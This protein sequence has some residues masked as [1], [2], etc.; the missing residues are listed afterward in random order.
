MDLSKTQIRR[1]E[2]YK[3]RWTSFGAGTGILDISEKPTPDVLKRY[4]IFEGLDDKFLERISPD[5]SIARWKKNSV[6]FEEGSYIDM[7]FFVVSGEVEVS[8]QKSRAGAQQL[9]IFNRSRTMVVGPGGF[10]PAVPAGGNT[11]FQSQIARQERSASSIMFLSSIDFNL[12][13]DGA[14]RLGAGE[15]FGE[16]GALSGW[17][18]S[19]TA[20]TVTECELVQV[21][22]AAL[23]MMKKRSNVLKSRLDSL[24]R[25]RSLFSQL[26]T[27]P[28]FE[29]LKDDA[30]RSLVQKVDLVSC[31][32]DE[33]IA[34]EREACDALYLVRSGFVKLSQ[35]LGEG[36]IVV[37]YLPKG[38]IFGDVELLIEG[39]SGWVFTVS[40]KEYSELVRLSRS[41]FEALLV[42][43]PDVKSILWNSV[44]NRLKESGYSRRVLRQS[45]FI[46]TALNTGLV[47]GN[48]VLVID[49]SVCTRCD[50]CVRGCASTHGGIP[51]FIREG[52]RIGDFLVT[53][54][55]YHCEDPVCLVG[56]PTGAIRRT[57]VG[58]VVAIDDKLCIGC[59]TCAN[60]CPYDAITMFETGDQWPADMIPEGLRGKE[61][62]LATKCDLCY[63]DPAGPACVRSCPHGCAFRVGDIKEFRDLL[64]K[65]V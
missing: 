45:E 3:D 62:Q 24:Y 7:A 59:S 31:E 28:L 14:M 38:G 49:L 17:P 51:R 36:T 13:S 12:P 47:E 48:S 63:T 20:K 53:R 15:I 43:Y 16:I 57:D 56:C 44:V 19:V 21:R 35:R 40:S 46:D 64:W 22:V 32:P 34:R 61:K 25:E 30:I 2:Q 50:D 8:L 10:A 52:D 26:K 55:C 5:V 11:V 65:Q 9:P 58:D 6:L 33:I 1:L 54:A 27:T 4:P 18:Q 29:R 42:Q 23:R 60:N 37:S 39:V 41:D